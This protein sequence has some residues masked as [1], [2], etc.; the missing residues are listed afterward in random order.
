MLKETFPSQ[1]L[2]MVYIKWQLKMCFEIARIDI[3]REPGDNC[4]STRMV[5]RSERGYELIAWTTNMNLKPLW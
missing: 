1:Q 2:I 3:Q 4:L 5:Q